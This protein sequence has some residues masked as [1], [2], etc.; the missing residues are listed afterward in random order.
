MNLG[1]RRTPML[2]TV[3]H[4]IIITIILVD[5]DDVWKDSVSLVADG[6]RS[7]DIGQTV[8]A[9]RCDFAAAA[10]R[11]AVADRRCPPSSVGILGAA[12]A[13]GRSPG[14]T[15]STAAPPRPADG[16]RRGGSGNRLFIV[17]KASHRILLLML[18]MMWHRFLL[19]QSSLVQLAQ[20][21]GV[22]LS[23]AARQLV[24]L[25]SPSR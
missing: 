11:L 25:I 4:L 12:S 5:G 18:V 2:A 24:Y 10:Q 16:R 9:G 17:I 13:Q 7:G 8:D 6:R 23:A 1:G 22:R 20:F 14:P 3:F 15:T 19:T 21:F